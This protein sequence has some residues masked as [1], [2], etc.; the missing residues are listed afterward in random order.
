MRNK[1]KDVT[2]K[3][4]TYIPEKRG[5]LSAIEENNV[6][7]SFKRV[8][9]VK[10]NTGDIRGNHAHIK[11]KQFMLCLNGEIEIIVDDGLSKKNFILNKPDIGVYVPNEI[12]S[13]QRYL[14]DESVLMVICDLDFDEKDYL[15]K[16]EDFKNFINN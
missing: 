5:E 8:F 14:R 6:P 1:I 12:W 16:Y 2:I 9:A 15:R 13:I 4:L 10:A 11:C 7:F 3:N